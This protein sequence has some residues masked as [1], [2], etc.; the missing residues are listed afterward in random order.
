ML[1]DEFGRHAW[2]MHRG[3]DK[4][5]RRLRHGRVSLPGQLYLVTTTT[6]ERTSL[7]ADF[8]VACAAARVI[9]AARPEYAIL[10]WVVMPDHLHALI[11]LNE[12]TLSR[13][14]GGLKARAAAAVNRVQ[15][16][17]NAVWARAFHDRALR[18][19][20]DVLEVARYIIC[21]PLR[22][23]LA[24]SVRDYPFWDAVWVAT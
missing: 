23:G 1:P 12:G 14:I 15:G 24:R 22:A 13:A 10:C 11:A 7:F 8:D 21:N 3:T 20:D 18:Y 9:A 19:E 2:P 5:H 16:G 6:I 4:G 17:R